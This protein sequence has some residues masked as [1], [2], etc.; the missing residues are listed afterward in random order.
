LVLD[1]FV[2]AIG[3]FDDEVN[4]FGLA[5]METRL[6]LEDFAHLDAIELL[7]ALGAG[8]PDS[9]TARGVEESELDADGVGNFAHDAAERVD[10]AD[11]MALG[12]TTDGRIAAHLGD[13]VEVHGDERGLEAHA[14]GSHGSLAAG[15]TGAHDNDI[16]LFGESH[17]SLFYG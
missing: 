7:V 17:P 8:A 5:D 4:N 10:L 6:R 15:V 14:R 13:E 9:G 1:C 3:F 12:D 2:T 16:V 11:E